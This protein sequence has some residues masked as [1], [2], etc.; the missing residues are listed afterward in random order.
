VFYYILF[1]VVAPW[2]MNFQML[3]SHLNRLKLEQEYESEDVAGKQYTNQRAAPE[4][5]VA[6]APKGPRF[7]GKGLQGDT[8]YQMSEDEDQEPEQKESETRTGTPFLIHGVNSPFTG[9][10]SICQKANC[11]L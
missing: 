7:G 3:W 11:I 6:N 9:Q 4:L 8:T 2:L 5:V 1:K 10:P